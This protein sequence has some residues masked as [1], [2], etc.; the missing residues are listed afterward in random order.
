MLVAVTGFGSIWTRRFGRDP[1][2]S[3]RHTL[4]AFYYN[5]TG[6]PIHGIVRPRARVYGVARFN[7]NSG[8]TPHCPA[9]MLNRVF[10]CGE[11]ERGA[12]A[13]QIL[14]RK[15][16]AAGDATPDRYLVVVTDTTAGWIERESAQWKSSECFLLSFSECDG[17]QEALLLMPAFGWV[18]GNSA[19]LVLTPHP[20]RPASARL[21][22][23]SK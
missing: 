2:S 11:P 12:A 15:L 8:F 10:E 9:R 14:F 19:F 23:H 22:A 21:I 13:N 18:Y 17:H 4:D 16:L 7:G 6:V 20:S 3:T 1:D 5:T